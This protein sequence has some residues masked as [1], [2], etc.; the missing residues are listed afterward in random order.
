MG[1]P[2]NFPGILKKKPLTHHFIL[3]ESFL[4]HPIFTKFLIKKKKFKSQS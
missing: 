2:K 4:E 1:H 3:K